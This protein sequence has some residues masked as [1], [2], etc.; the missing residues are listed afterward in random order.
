MTLSMKFKLAKDLKSLFS[1]GLIYT[2]FNIFN[3]IIP[4]VLLPI[5]VSKLSTKD[6]GL[7]SYFVTIESLLI[8]FVTFNLNAALSR[9]FY[10]SYYKISDYIST[11]FYFIILFLLICL[12]TSQ[13]LPNFIFEFIGISFLDFNYA[14]VASSVSGLIAII[15]NLLR[16]QRR[17]FL[18]G[19]FAI[20]QSLCL[21]ILIYLF[22]IKESSYEMIIF[23]R[24]SYYTIFFILLVLFLINT[25]YIKKIFRY[26]YL[27]RA[28]KFSL[29]TLVYSISAIIFLS[30]DRFFIKSILG[31]KQLGYYAAVFQLSSVI[32]LIGVS[33][34]AAWMPW[35]FEKLK[36]KDYFTD[37]LIVKTSYI[38]IIFLI[39]I[40]FIAC[41][42]FPY[43][44]I[45]ILP[46]EFHS[47]FSISYPI[48]FGFVFEGIYLIVSP[49]LFYTE[50]T[51]YNA[52]AGI[53]VAIVNVTLNIIFIPLLGIYGAALTSF[54]SWLLLSVM[55]FFLSYKFYP[56]P[57]LFF[58]KKVKIRESNNL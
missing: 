4:F 56:M 37:L 46:K 38:L 12:L 1:D 17:A 6:F 15:S 11:I 39:L 58:L 9:H 42:F 53:L 19:L 44:A 47:Y 20:F 40:G 25:K 41:F 2:G 36:R 28:L 43:L 7:Y 52:Y 50:K 33:I 54:I 3:K 22:V 30:S 45:Y 21:F 14:L 51:I 26:G 18:F 29:P 35:L 24:L 13:L 31:E 32:S 57:W 8:P 23:G 27:L 10:D 48:I 49:Y 55:F 5:I 16:L 34:N